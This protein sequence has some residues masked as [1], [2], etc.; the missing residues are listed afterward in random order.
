MKFILTILTLS[1]FNSVFSQT[2][3]DR[4]WIQFTDKNNS[5]YSLS[6]PQDYLSQRAIDRRT[7]QG[8]S[9]QINDLPVNPQYI[10][11]LRS[12]GVQIIH[13]SKWFNSVTIKETNQAVVDS[14]NNLSFVETY[15]RVK[16]YK[17]NNPVNRERKK[18]VLK[19]EINL[20]SKSY[21]YGY[22]TNQIQ[23]LNGHKLHELGYKGQDIQIA[24]I[25]AGFFNADSNPVFDSLWADNQ[26][27]ATANFIDTTTEDIFD[28]HSHGMMVLSVIAANYPDSMIGT[29][30]KADFYLLRSEDGNSENIIEE[31]SWVAAAEFAD[32][33]G[34][35]IINSSLG[36]TT[37]DDSTQNHTYNDLDGNTTRVSIGADIA[38]SKGMLVVV[39]AGNSGNFLW[40]YISTPADA[41]SVL[42]IGSVDDLENYSSFSS[43]GPTADGRIKPDVT[44]M[45]EGT[46]IQTAS[47]GFG[48]GNGTSLSAPLISGLAA[49]LWQAH[50][51]FSN[52]ELMQA[53][54]ISAD[55]YNNPDN[56]KG[57]GIPDFEYA[58]NYL[59]S[60]EMQENHV[61]KHVKV[62]PNPFID[63]IRIEIY[64]VDSHDIKLNIFDNRGK[65]VR[66]K[67]IE[68]NRG[69]TFRS[70]NI[71]DLKNLPG[72]IY[73]LNIKTDNFEFEEKLIKYD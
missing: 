35:D 2:A 5:P 7:N 16:T 26:V 46:A 27:L 73:I 62:F 6:S 65:L 11:S 66:E 71:N 54:K 68:A 30:P 51:S 60:I 4:F 45:G 18:T 61:K 63:D 55:Q 29:A 44:A 33:A 20:K 40:H 43:V 31:D 12:F 64:P 53:I 39:A 42:T 67:I 24:V 22:S 13:K 37:F 59:L 57:Y 1:L 19:S 41:D 21:N 8:V 3:P 17:S 49:C 14:I 9:I 69:L 48:T 50:P 32:S 52:M 25:D 58:H 36:Y 23:M 70:F 34:A 15:R 10:D 56:E 28:L 47:G 72:G 38:A